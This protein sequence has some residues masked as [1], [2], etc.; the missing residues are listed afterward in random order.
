MAVSVRLLLAPA[1]RVVGR[2]IV[3]VVRG[4]M[5]AQMVAKGISSRG[6]QA[7]ALVSLE[8]LPGVVLVAIFHVAIIMQA[9]GIIRG[10][11]L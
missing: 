2:Q 8:M 10:G 3:V 4:P 7:E 9:M 1:R 6:N 11:T 5:V